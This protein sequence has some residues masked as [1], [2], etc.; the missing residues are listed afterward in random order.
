[1]G[2]LLDLEVKE[3]RE[4]TMTAQVADRFTAANHRL[5]LVGD[6]AHR[7]PPAGGFGMN[8]GIQDVHNLA[9]KVAA[10]LRGRAPLALIRSYEAE[11]R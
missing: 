11:R 1:M 2:P 3:V 5:I 6:A 10:V 4:W 8:S 9:W 7:F